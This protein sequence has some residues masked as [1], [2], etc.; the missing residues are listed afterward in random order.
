[1]LQHTFLKIDLRFLRCYLIAVV[2][3][4]FWKFTSCI[5]RDKPCTN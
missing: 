4:L 5:Y 1:L 3:P 2:K